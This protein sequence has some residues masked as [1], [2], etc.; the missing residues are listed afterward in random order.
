[1]GKRV[2]EYYELLNE[3]QEDVLELSEKAEGEIEEEVKDIGRKIRHEMLDIQMESTRPHREAIELGEEA[4]WRLDEEE[5]KD[6][7]EQ[8]QDIMTS[9]EYSAPEM[10]V[11]C[12][13]MFGIVQ[14]IFDEEEFLDMAERCNI[15]LEKVE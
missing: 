13:R 10:T 3:I 8:I 12:K 15:E 1:M 7:I 6:K 4:I 11:H 14:N 5:D 9:V 2:E